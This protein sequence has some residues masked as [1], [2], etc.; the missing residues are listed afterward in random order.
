VPRREGG[1]HFRGTGPVSI[2]MAG[3]VRDLRYLKCFMCVR[4]MNSAAVVTKSAFADWN[5]YFS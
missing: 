1:E 5:V 3:W 4:G 2:E